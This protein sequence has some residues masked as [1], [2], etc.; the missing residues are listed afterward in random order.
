MKM[1]IETTPEQRLLCAIFGERGRPQVDDK[2]RYLIQ[3]IVDTLHPRERLVLRLR[4]GLGGQ[5]PMTLRQVAQQLPCR[6][7]RGSAVPV[8][9]GLSPERARQIQ[10][11]ALRRLRHPSRSRKLTH[12]VGCDS[13]FK[14]S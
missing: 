1:S 5:P 13:I 11:K 10:A 3:G 4:F 9:Y 7:G 12:M 8:E 14:A 2:G 6:V